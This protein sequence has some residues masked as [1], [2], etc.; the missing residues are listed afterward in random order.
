MACGTRH[1][2]E[3]RILSLSG[4]SGGGLDNVARSEPYEADEPLG[5]ATA[6]SNGD[7]PPKPANE[8]GAVPVSNEVS[9]AASAKV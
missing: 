3:R 4:L 9:V 1:K 5:D 8:I 7:M 2:F 6:S